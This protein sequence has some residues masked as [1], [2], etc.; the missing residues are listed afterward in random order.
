M[1]HFKLPESHSSFCLDNL[2]DCRYT[3][4][5]NEV[6]RGKF[7]RIEV[8]R[9]T[10]FSPRSREQ[11]LDALVA[12]IDAA[13]GTFK[14]VPDYSTPEARKKIKQKYIE[15]DTCLDAAMPRAFLRSVGG[16]GKKSLSGRPRIS[17]PDRGGT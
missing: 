3:S 14:F 1:I 15:L 6:D 11:A 8:E 13:A 17:N 9:D 2:D 16:M 12:A 5:Q 7:T 4:M 10:E